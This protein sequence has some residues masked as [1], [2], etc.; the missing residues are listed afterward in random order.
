MAMYVPGCVVRPGITSKSMENRFAS[1][2]PGC[3][4]EHIRFAQCKLHEGSGSI[5]LEMLRY[6][7]HDNVLPSVVTLSTFVPLSVNSAKGLSRW[8]WRC[9]ATLS[10]TELYALY[11]SVVCS[12]RRCYPAVDV[13]NVQSNHSQWLE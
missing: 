7:Q 5:G 10:M 4:P 13:F 3:H 6:A 2:V 11:D 12:V 1:G 8:A 9:F